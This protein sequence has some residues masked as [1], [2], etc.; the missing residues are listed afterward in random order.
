MPS[1]GSSLTFGFFTSAFLRFGLA[2]FL[3][4]YYVTS[5]T[6]PSSSCYALDNTSRLV[7]FTEWT[8]HTFEYDGKDADLV[9]RFC[10]DVE[11]CSQA[12]Y[13][14]FGRYET[15]NYFAAGS[16]PVDFVQGYY[17]GDLQNCE[18]SFDQMGRISQVDII[19]GSCLNGACTGQ[20]GCICSV[21][22]DESLCRVHAQLAI[23]CTN[24]G[25]RVFEGFTVGFH[26]R[27]WE[28]VSNGMT[29]LGYEK[30][31]NEFSFGTEQT[32]VSLYLTAKFSLSGLVRK[33]LIKV[34]PDKGLEVKLTGS[35]ENGRAPTT[36]SPTVLNIYWRCEVA[37][38]TPYEIKIMVPVD[39]YD[40]I[41]FTLTKLCDYRQEREDDSTNGWATF[42]VLSC[43]YV[44]NQYLTNCCFIVSSMIICCGGFFYK[45]RVEHQHG[46]DALPGITVLSA[47]LDKVSG[48]RSY[49]LGD[50]D[51]HNFANQTSWERP[52]A[53]AQGN[54]RTE[55]T[56]YGSI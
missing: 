21:S 20:S 43:M 18:H 13:I 3:H 7:D 31:H 12:G 23:P 9:V 32:H 45:S 11:R 54:P 46:L 38:D 1:G 52:S 15:S 19:C 26:P 39:G 27:S 47:L 48:S 6:V 51:S 14:D 56:R 25:S 33:P 40:P 2:T 8:G 30:L 4:F 42:G 24:R 53:S 55:E 17:N 50:V 37:R 29:Q 49:R 22:Y 10:K 34:N 5:L 44:S 16:A 35:A 28:I 41:G 36:L